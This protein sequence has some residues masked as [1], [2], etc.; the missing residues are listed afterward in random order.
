MAEGD[1]HTLT[2]WGTF[3][4]QIEKLPTEGRQTEVH[5]CDRQLP[6]GTCQEEPGAAE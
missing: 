6:D 1:N 5:Q 2:L 3:P 4:L